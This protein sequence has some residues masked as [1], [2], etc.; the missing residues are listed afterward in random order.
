MKDCLNLSLP[1]KNSKKMG[2]LILYSEPS[3]KKREVSKWACRATG[4]EETYSWSYTPSKT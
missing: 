1:E 3:W 4:I 2:A